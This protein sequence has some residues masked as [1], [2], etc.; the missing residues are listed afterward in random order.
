MKYLFFIVSI[1]AA[2][3]SYAQEYHLQDKNINELSGLVVSTKSD[4]LLWVHNDSGDKS[5]VYLIN[6][7]GEKITT[8]DYHK[9]V[10]DCEDIALYHAKNG[11]P[12]IFV[13]DIGDNK[14]K[15]EYISLYKFE[16][17]NTHKTKDKID[18]KN[19]KE[20]KL[21][22]PDGPKDAECLMIDPLD[23]KI[24]IVSKRE[25]SV[26]VYSAAID[27]PPNKP[28]TLKKEATLFFPGVIHLKWITAGDISRDGTQVL[29]KSYG[30]IFYWNRKTNESFIDCIK[31]PY[32]IIPYKPE[33]QGEAIGFT[34]D[35]K[36]FY[37]IS[38]GKEAVI[39]Y[40]DLN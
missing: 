30:N 38:E 33:P 18:I 34:K 39:F 17:P 2:T 36:H 12:E 15:R 28:T 6:N 35:A 13:G 10:K 37:T 11:K 16:E 40:K 25:D 5:Y 1:F 26:K 8:I 29:I 20:I 4:D 32:K 19:A 14:A 21:K 3:F 27:T 24:Y 9:D 7:K 22:Y 23:K 31:K